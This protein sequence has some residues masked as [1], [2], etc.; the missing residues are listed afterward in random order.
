MRGAHLVADVVST[1]LK[2]GRG[3]ATLVFAVDRA[4]AKALQES[5]VA[6]GVRTE[7]VDAFTSRE[8]RDSIRRRMQA[9]ETE[10]VCNI[11][12]LTTGCDWPFVSCIV[13][14]RPTKSVMLYVQIV[15]RGLRTH[16]AKDRCLV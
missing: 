6:V 10:V 8:E 16:P 14:A 12:C 1:W 4:H 15:G 7:Y 2:R 11:G 3:R 5:F 9:G 13:L